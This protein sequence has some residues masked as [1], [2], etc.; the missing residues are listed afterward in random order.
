M[1][2]I[3]NEHGYVGVWDLETG[4]LGGQEGHTKE[5]SVFAAT[6]D[7]RWV[8]SGG[9]DGLLRIWDLDDCRSLKILK[10]HTNALISLLVTA[11]GQKA[12][13]LSRDQ[14]LRLWDLETGLCLSAIRLDKVMMGDFC[15]KGNTLLACSSYGDGEL[16]Q[17]IEPKKGNPIEIPFML[18]VTPCGDGS[19]ICREGPGI[20]KRPCL[21]CVRSAG[22]A[23]RCLQPLLNLSGK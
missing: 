20:G 21:P 19:T 18:R 11:D 16:F 15:L 14:T 4:E 7:G 6:T 9:E 1:G 17:I 3:R 23:V 22:R 13:S 10:G 12:V 5:V 2:H 8:L